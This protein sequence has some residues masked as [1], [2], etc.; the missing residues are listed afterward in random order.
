[1]TKHFSGT[2]WHYFEE[3]AEDPET[4]ED[5]FSDLS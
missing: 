1:M 3:E 4:V 2:W 5:Q